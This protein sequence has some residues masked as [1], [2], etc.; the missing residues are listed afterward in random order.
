MTMNTSEINF[1]ALSLAVTSQEKP[2]WTCPHCGYEIDAFS[3]DYWR[4][5]PNSASD[6]LSDQKRQHLDYNCDGLFVKYTEVMKSWR[7][8]NKRDRILLPS[9]RRFIASKREDVP[10]RDKGE[11]VKI[12]APHWLQWLNIKTYMVIGVAGYGRDLTYLLDNG[13]IVEHYDLLRFNQTY[14]EF[15]SIYA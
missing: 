6:H 5:W 14:M 12:D 11:Y 7:T 9:E 15:E 3:D 4:E 1:A 13:D 10:L 2:E 8:G